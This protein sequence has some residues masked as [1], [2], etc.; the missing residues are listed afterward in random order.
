MTKGLITNLVLIAAVIVAGIVT[1]AL[2]IRECDR[3]G[4][5]IQRIGAYYACVKERK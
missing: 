5:K 1:I 3:A 2:D 4:G